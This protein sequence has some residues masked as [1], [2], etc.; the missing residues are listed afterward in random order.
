M[1]PSIKLDREWAKV[2]SQSYQ[3]QTKDMYFR[4]L[5][6]KHFF[7]FLRCG[8]C[9]AISECSDTDVS[10]IPYMLNDISIAHVCSLLHICSLVIFAVPQLFVHLEPQ[11]P[12]SQ[13]T[14]KQ[15]QQ[16]M[17]QPDLNLDDDKE[18]NKAHLHKEDERRAHFERM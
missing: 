4:N 3:F 13:C 2:D 9:R 11:Q 16:Q 18:K 5:P 15:E 6:N 17:P 14:N 1:H 7:N 10:P 8:N 12:A